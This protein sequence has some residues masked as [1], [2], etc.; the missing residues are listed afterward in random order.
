M[1]SGAA[2]VIASDA[3]GALRPPVLSPAVDAV[4]ADGM[5]RAAAESL[6][7]VMPR[8]LLRHGLPAVRAARAA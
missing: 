8:A 5:P 6:V 3:H 1:R 7:S 2:D 4:V